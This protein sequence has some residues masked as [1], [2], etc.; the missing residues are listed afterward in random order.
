MVLG[1]GESLDAEH[2]ESGTSRPVV[3]KIK[4]SGKKVSF[5]REALM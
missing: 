1:S 5:Q 3:G 2:G 4:V